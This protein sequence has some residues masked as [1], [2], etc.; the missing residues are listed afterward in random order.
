ML[1]TCATSALCV[2]VGNSNRFQCQAPA[3]GAGEARC[4]NNGTLAVCNAARTGFNVANC[5][6]L[7]CSANP[8]RC[9]SLLGI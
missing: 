3:C 4:Q 8:P 6:R 1:Q 7:G 2:Q 9:R 5:G